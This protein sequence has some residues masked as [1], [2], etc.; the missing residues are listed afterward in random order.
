MTL[1]IVWSTAGL[2]FMLVNIFF[3]QKIGRRAISVSS[4][5]YSLVIRGFPL[6]YSSA[7]V[8][9]VYTITAKNKS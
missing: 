5:Q 9:F 1:S 6:I 4:I 7:L 2:Y 3:Y 8:K